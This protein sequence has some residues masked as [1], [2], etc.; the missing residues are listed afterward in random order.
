MFLSVISQI[1]QC[2]W[3]TRVTVLVF[4]GTVLEYVSSTI[5][6]LSKRNGH[7]YVVGIGFGFFVGVM[8]RGIV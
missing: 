5:R 3:N 7:L 2:N 4:T 6:D 8:W 1:I